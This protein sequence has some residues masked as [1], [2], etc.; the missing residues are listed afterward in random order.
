MIEVRVQWEDSEVER[1]KSCYAALEAEVKTARLEDK[2]LSNW[3]VFYH[4][5][6]DGPMSL[7]GGWK[8]QPAET[9]QVQKIFAGLQEHQDT[10]WGGGSGT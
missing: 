7:R 9:S 1:M 2:S 6:A 3:G 8:K 5:T 10:Q 4:Q